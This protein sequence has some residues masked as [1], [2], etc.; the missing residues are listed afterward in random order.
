M[1]KWN[2]F[3]I[4]SIVMYYLL[5]STTLQ[6]FLKTVQYRNSVICGLGA[7]KVK[8]YNKSMKA[9]LFVNKRNVTRKLKTC[10]QLWQILI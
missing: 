9:V 8:M 4:Y 10:T 5:N 7:S 2:L 3:S 6:S 1:I